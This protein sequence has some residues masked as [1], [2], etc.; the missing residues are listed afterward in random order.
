M[1]LDKETAGVTAR[2]ADTTR[3]VGWRTASRP[4]EWVTPLTGTLCRNRSEHFPCLLRSAALSPR[5]GSAPGRIQAAAAPHRTGNGVRHP[6]ARHVPRSLPA[7]VAQPVPHLCMSPG[8][9]SPPR[10]HCPGVGDTT[11]LRV[12]PSRILRWVPSSRRPQRGFGALLTHRP[13]RDGDAKPRVAE[14]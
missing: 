7:Q 9:K 5:Q 13:H 12:L 1:V 2:K 4:Q 11:G 3:G 6:Q 8:A 14:R 10:C